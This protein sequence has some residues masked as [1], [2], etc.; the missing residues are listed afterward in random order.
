MTPWAQ[1]I[2]NNWLLLS[3]SQADV[4]IFATY[5]KP[6]PPVGATSY[7]L[8]LDW[9]G[10]GGLYSGAGLGGLPSAAQGDVLYVFQRQSQAIGP[11][12]GA[13][14]ATFATAF[15]RLTSYPA[16]VNGGTAT[17]D[18][19]L[20]PA[21]IAT[22]ASNLKPSAFDALLPEM[23]PS[24]HPD[25]TISNTGLGWAAFG[26]P[27]VV[28]GPDM[29]SGPHVR[30]G[31]LST[32]SGTPDT[33]YGAVPYGDFLDPLWKK[34][35]QINYFGVAPVAA[36]GATPVDAQVWYLAMEALSPA[37]ANP[38]VP[39]LG[40]VQAP[41][42]AG[43]DATSNIATPVGLQPVISWS[44]PS[45]GTANVYYVS[46]SELLND[47]G[48][49]NMVSV[50][51]ATLYGDLSFKVPPG[52]LKAGSTYVASISAQ[53]TPWMVLDGNPTGRGVPSYSTDRLTGNFTP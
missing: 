24:G 4:E 35:R 20:A 13:A 21:P 33:D 37:P 27:H 34:V 42:I 53:N 31:W 22:M 52:F 9:S 11:L 43:V 7:S 48:V 1:S 25:M 14:V 17:L 47:G 5:G 12:A 29:P 28:L 16:F 50:F 10:I 45:L 3:S 38:V 40:P 19:S 36:P 49:T 23:A 32:N 15:A 2:T 51:S 39:V 6:K 18:V 46:I 30:L 41:R 8:T 26:V 44:P